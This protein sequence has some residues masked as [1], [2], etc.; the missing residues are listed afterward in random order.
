MQFNTP[1]SRVDRELSFEFEMDRANKQLE[2]KMKTPWK[3]ADLSGK[4][5]IWNLDQIKG[6]QDVFMVQI[7][8][9]PFVGQL[10]NTEALRSLTARAT[11]DDQMV[12]SV[13]ARLSSEDRRNAMRYTPEV[14]V[15]IPGREDIILDGSVTHVQSRKFDVDLQLKNLFQ[16]PVTL[17]G[18]N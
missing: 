15:V 9:I 8:A 5:L 13:T 7:D 2:F 17:K 6:F 10:V 12:Y 16:V 11:I 14:I 3:K 18:E 4:T 1:G